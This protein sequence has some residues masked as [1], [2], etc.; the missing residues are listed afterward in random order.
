M[1]SLDLSNALDEVSSGSD[2]EDGKDAPLSLLSPTEQHYIDN[3][4][5]MLS[6]ATMSIGGVM[7]TEQY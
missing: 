7:T 2:D 5:M 4:R 6:L 3:C 1:P